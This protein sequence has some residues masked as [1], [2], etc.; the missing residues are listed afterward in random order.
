MLI[1]L[2]KF[3]SGQNQTKQ[4]RKKKKNNVCCDE[5]NVDHAIV[6]KRGG[7]TIQ[8]HN[9]LR[10][11]EVEMFKL[12]CS[13]VEEEPVLQELTGV[14]IPTKPRMCDSICTPAC[15]GRGKNLRWAYCQIRCIAL[16]VLQTSNEILG[17][18]VPS[19]I[20]ADLLGNNCLFERVQK[21][22]FCDL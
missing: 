5:F 3:L 7:F 13:R 17:I 2:S 18:S 15:C 10:V 9:E 11:L 1:Y 14:V 6:C 22:M 19:I 21:V 8:H 4:N 12:V 20:L 16:L